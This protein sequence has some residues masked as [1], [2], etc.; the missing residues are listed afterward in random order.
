M[1]AFQTS[2][3]QRA[4]PCVALCC[5]LHLFPLWCFDNPWAST[6][7]CFVDSCQGRKRAGRAS[8]L[9]EL[10]RRAGGG[11]TP[12]PLN[13]NTLHVHLK[14]HMYSKAFLSLSVYNLVNS[15]V[16]KCQYDKCGRDVIWGCKRRGLDLN[17]SWVA[18]L[19][20][21]M[22]IC[23]WVNG[24]SAYKINL[25]WFAFC[26][27][28]CENQLSECLHFVNSGFWV[29]RSISQELGRNVQ[30]RCCIQLMMR[31]ASKCLRSDSV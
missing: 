17:C 5:T 27:T 16:N 19:L 30:H 6:C 9:H 29:T 13:P 8:P 22:F 7:C 15:H 18:P 1:S 23:S 31:A 14:T 3:L 2:R 4:R 11:P 28:N 24:L 21:R 26:W 25:L 12:P 20:L 10:T